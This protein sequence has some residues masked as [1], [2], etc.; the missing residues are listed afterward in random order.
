MMRKRYKFISETVK[1]F[2]NLEEYARQKNECFSEIGVEP[3]L[4]EDCVSLYFEFPGNEY[5]Q[6]F[7]IPTK[8]GR[9][10]VSH[11]IWWQND[12]CANELLNIF[13]GKTY[14]NE[15]VIFPVC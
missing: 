1:G 4:K 3:E 8:D 13:T 2:T 11:V 7:V 5:E 10:T 6:Y 15:D 14:D 9:L 12:L